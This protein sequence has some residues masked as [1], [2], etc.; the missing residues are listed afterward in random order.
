MTL[1]RRQQGIGIPAAIFVITLLA[2]ISVA[3]SSLV[4]DN[5]E[6]IQEE[7]LLTRAFYAAESGAGFGMNALFPPDEFPLYERTPSGTAICDAGPREYTLEAEGLNACEVS[8]KCE[9]DATVE[10]VE[11]YSITSTATCFDVVRTIQVRTSFEP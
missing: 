8:V 2:V 7:V 1:L 6:T 4:S 3:I 9:L 5:A 11:Y 10:G